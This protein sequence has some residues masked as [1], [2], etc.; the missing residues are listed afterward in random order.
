MMY[1]SKILIFHS[2]LEFPGKNPAVFSHLPKMSL[3]V[4]PRFFQPKIPVFFDVSHR[5]LTARDHPRVGSHCFLGKVLEATASERLRIL[6]LRNVLI[7]AM[8]RFKTT[9]GNLGNSTILYHIIS[10]YISYTNS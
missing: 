4:F 1:L 8:V 2:Y 7:C 6:C 10:N 3:F 9:L 5:S